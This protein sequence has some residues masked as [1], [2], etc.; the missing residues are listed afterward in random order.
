MFDKIK[1]SIQKFSSRNVADR[2]AVEQLTKDIQRDLIRADVDVSL[3]SDL[4]D[5]IKEE[6]LE[7]DLPSGLSRKEHVLKIVYDRLEDLLGEEADVEVEPKNILLS[8]LYGAGKTTTAGKLADFYRK[9]GLKVGLIAADTDRPAAY[10]QLKQIADDVD[11]QFFGDPE[12]ENP[13][14]VVEKGMS[15]L[16]ADVKI[17]DSAGRDSL[18]D[19]LK[20]ELSAISES[21]S[22]DEKYL[23]MPADIGQS[24]REQTDMFDEAAGLT[25]V[26]VTKMDSSAKGGGALVACANSDSSV[27]FIG[28]GEKMGDLEQYDPVDFVS[29]MIGQ[30]DLESLL[31]KI[32]EMDADPEAILEGEFTMQDF[33]EQIES[34]TQAGVMEEMMQQLPFSSN[35]LPDNMQ[36]M[37]EGKIENYT[38]IMDSLTDEEMRDPSVIK[39]SRKER[40]AE[41]SGT[42]K[43]E[44]GELVKH[45]KQTKNMVNK[46]DKNSMKR[47]NMKDMMSKIG[48]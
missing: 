9:R 12:A 22:P 28:T 4:T 24:A 2:E 26:I 39:G 36:D 29:D 48:F 13:V 7:E 44:V 37:T 10:N 1:D 27:Q 5:E 33:K 11:A 16:D 6:A 35:Q 38:I 15:Q 21:F 8:G 23:V 41:G 20:K 34:V 46:F 42:S 45:F 40:I 17:V 30:P 31:E 47:G 14:K 18:D 3:V 25:G 32:E 19:D 43:S